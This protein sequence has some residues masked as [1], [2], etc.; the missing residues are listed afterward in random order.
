MAETG[1][2]KNVRY[3][4]EPRVDPGE[5]LA[6]YHAQNHPAPQS[7]EKI[8]RMID[9]SACFITARDPGGRLIGIA[10]GLS[11]GVRGYLTECKLD[12]AHQGP[13]A[14]TRTDGR[15]EHDDRGIA[16]E[17]AQR[18]LR[19]LSEMGC[20]RIEVLAYGTEVD[21]CEELGF[22]RSSGMVALTLDASRV[23]QGASA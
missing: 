12:P 17:M 5:V 14:V 10:R 13:A 21:F 22:R 23:P 2:L 3:A 8:R 4:I 15:I 7:P 16:R 19:A 20:D 9:S 6:F 18:V 1:T 11:D